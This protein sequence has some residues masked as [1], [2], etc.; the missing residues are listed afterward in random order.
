[1]H[2]FTA[3]QTAQAFKHHPHKLSALMGCAA[4]VG[5]SSAQQFARVVPSDV[6]LTSDQRTTSQ[7][8]MKYFDAT[9]PTADASGEASHASY[10]ESTRRIQSDGSAP[11]V[12]VIFMVSEKDEVDFDDEK[13]SSYKSFAWQEEPA[14][15]NVA[16]PP[17]RLEHEMN[18]DNVCRFMRRA[19]RHPRR[20]RQV[21]GRGEE[22]ED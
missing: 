14:P 21:I 7:Q 15:R 6:A 22:A 19:S 20:F 9:S 2:F 1:M 12:G 3:S 18:I 11:S 13:L 5:T 4:S 17:G 16:L 10:V 8:G